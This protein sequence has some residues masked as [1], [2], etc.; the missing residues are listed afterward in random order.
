MVFLQPHFRRN[1]LDSAE[2]FLAGFTGRQE[3]DAFRR[4]LWSLWDDISH[5]DNVMQ[6]LEECQ[7]TLQDDLKYPEDIE[8]PEKKKHLKDLIERGKQW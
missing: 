2:R 8:K 6:W 1:A 4:T 5:D 7:K 3:L